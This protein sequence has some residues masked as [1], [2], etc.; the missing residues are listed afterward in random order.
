MAK[1]IVIVGTLDTK[2]E[3]HL[4]LKQRIEEKGLVAIVI[5]TGVIGPPYFVPDVSREQ[6]SKAAGYEI[7]EL[8]K[9]QERKFAIDMMALGASR[10]VRRLYEEGNLEGIISIGGGQGT[11]ISSTAMKELPFGIP[12]VMVSTT[13]SGDMSGYVGYKDITLMHS[14]ADILGLNFFNRRF[15]SQAA[16]AICGM[17][18]E[19]SSKVEGGKPLIGMTMF[20]MT[21]PCVMKIKRLF[22]SRNKKYDIIV[23]HARGSGGRAMEELIREGVIKGVMDVTTTEL[24][25]E[26]VGGVRSAG[27]NRLEAAG[28]I[29]IPQLIGPGALDMVNFGPMESVPKVFGGRKFYVHTPMVTVMRTSPD[30]NRRLGEIMAEKLNRAKGKLVVIIPQKGFSGLDELGKPFYDADCSLS[31]ARSLKKNLDQEIKVIELDCHI[32]D[33]SYAVEVVNRF[34]EILP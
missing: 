27:P 20:G 13:V 29:G 25:D 15:F 28:E 23:F 2:G 10:I 31:F 7:E 22:E 32:N 1:K 9:K 24:A 26:L 34:L 16:S 12:K 19:D 21:T 30:E 18:N 5:D 11:Y 3:E 14:I 17:V 4:F 33:D 6:V 8:A